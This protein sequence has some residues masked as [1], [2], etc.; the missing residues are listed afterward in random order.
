[1]LIDYKVIEDQVTPKINSL[2]ATKTYQ[3]KPFKSQRNANQNTNF[4]NPIDATKSLK[5]K[6]AKEE[7]GKFPPL[8]Y[9][10]KLSK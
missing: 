3:K 7:G 8:L 6:V 2:K 4:A 5:K 10:I 1:M 9:L